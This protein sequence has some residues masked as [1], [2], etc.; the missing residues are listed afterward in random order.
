MSLYDIYGN[1]VVSGDTTESNVQNWKGRNGIFDGDSITSGYKLPETVGELLGLS[2]V[3]NIA[4]SGQ[5]IGNAPEGTI[6]HWKNRL[7]NYKPDVD[8]VYIMGDINSGDNPT[9]SFGDKTEDTWYGRWFLFLS[10]IKEMYPSIPV[11]LVATFANYKNS[12][13]IGTYRYAEAFREMAEYHGCIFINLPMECQLA[14]VNLKSA[15]AWSTTGTQ[16]V[17]QNVERAKKYLYPYIAK[18]INEYIPIDEADETAIALDKNTLTVAVGET[19][20]LASTLT[21]SN[22]ISQTN[23]WNIDNTDIAYIAAGAVH[24]RAAGT[25][26]ITVETRH[27]HKATCEVT[28][29]EADAE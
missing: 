15:G 14:M 1:V 10:A 18:R 26:T 6:G 29:T 13:S 16:N 12:T 17:H 19:A 23:V 7:N 24:A 20:Q 11:F 4:L 3:Y 8:F 28:V 22:A 5:S 2:K 9:G 25:A 21:P 27:G